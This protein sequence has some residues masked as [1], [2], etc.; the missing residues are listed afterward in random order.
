MNKIEQVPPAVSRIQRG[1]PFSG[2][3]GPLGQRR[4]T[5]LKL[6]LEIQRKKA[7]GSAFNIDACADPSNHKTAFYFTLDESAGMPLDGL[8]QPWR[9]LDG[10]PGVVWVQPP[11]EDIGPWIDK[12]IREVFEA[13][14]NA[15]QAVALLPGRTG[16]GW[17]IDAARW[18]HIE[19]IRGRPNCPLPEPARDTKSP[20]EDLVVIDFHRPFEWK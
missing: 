17:W 18:G 6:F 5:P 8:A 15:E 13:P 16:Q 7:F 19:A 10:T 2:N 3:T 14:Y 1:F 20:S 12:A 4:A 11:W 9:L